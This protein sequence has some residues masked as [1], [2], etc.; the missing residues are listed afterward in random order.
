[1]NDQIKKIFR[2]AFESGKKNT[3]YEVTRIWKKYEYVRII[4]GDIMGN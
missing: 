1:M 4:N 3:V 2:N